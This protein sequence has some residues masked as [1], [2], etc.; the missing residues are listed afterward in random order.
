MSQKIPNAVSPGKHASV[1]PVLPLLIFSILCS[2]SF[3]ERDHVIFYLKRGATQCFTVTAPAKDQLTGEVRVTNGEG[4]MTIGFWVIVASTNQI[5]L[6]R[7]NAEHEKF[8][9][10]TPEAPHGGLGHLSPP[11]E[12]KLCVFNREAFKPGSTSDSRK[13]YITFDSSSDPDALEDAT[14]T[15]KALRGVAR[16]KDVNDMKAVISTIERTLNAVREEIDAIRDRETSLFEITARVAN[17]IWIMGILSCAAI[18]A[19]GFFQLHQTHDE[20]R[21]LGAALSSEGRQRT[22]KRMRRTGSL[23]LPRGIG[24]L[25]GSSMGKGGRRDSLPSH[26]GISRTASMATLVKSDESRQR[27]VT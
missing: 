7:S 4:D 6:S 11:S 16:Q 10:T 22:R 17:Q 19:A 24:S 15:A 27:A 1:F 5:L 13:V 8:T 14:E 20:L 25:V 9:V 2:S 3:A 23:V 21:V 26:V 18:S 12:Y